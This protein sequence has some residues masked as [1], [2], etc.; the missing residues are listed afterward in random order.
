MTRKIAKNGKLQVDKKDLSQIRSLIFPLTH[1]DDNFNIFS[2]KVGKILSM[3]AGYLKV[4]DFPANRWCQGVFMYRRANET[5]KK[6]G[7]IWL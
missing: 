4:F 5:T 1:C 6:F 3:M 2:R 7:Y